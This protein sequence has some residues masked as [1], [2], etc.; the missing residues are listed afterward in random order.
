MLST[1]LGAHVTLRTRPDVVVAEKVV[2]AGSH[3]PVRVGL[4]PVTLIKLSP[5]GVG[6]GAGVAIEMAGVGVGVL[7][8]E[9][10]WGEGSVL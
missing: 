4:S 10:G 5:A 6:V 8:V 2:A 1:P 9:I 3:V 7:V